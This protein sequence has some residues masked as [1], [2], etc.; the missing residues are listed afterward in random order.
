MKRAKYCLL[1]GSGLM[2][3]MAVMSAALG[4]AQQAPQELLV[5]CG[6]TMVRPITE[7]ARNFEKEQD[8]KIIVSQGGSEELYQSLKK[9][10][11]GDLYL[12]GEASFL[13]NH[14]GEGLFGEST[15]VGFNQ[16]ALVVAKGN[17][18][19]VKPD[20]NEFLRKD[21]AVAIGSPESGSIGYQTRKVLQSV[22][23]YEKVVEK[24]V[25]LEGDSRNLNAALRRDEVDLIM[26]WRATA[27]FPDNIEKMD[28]IDLD[29]EL[30]KPEPLLLT[31]LKFSR[32]PTTARRFMEFAASPE[33]QTIFRKYGFIDNQGA[34]R[35]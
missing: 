15:N 21:L 33:G 9:S 24:A 29:A 4:Y 16:A 22:G 25:F 11:Q 23:L 1:L 5:Y 20:L 32:Y 10:G 26:N 3:W 7:I 8:A 17:P 31:F 12:P 13:Q 14:A 28:V 19:K 18:K 27:F 30:A 6:I 2:F 35:P 34:V